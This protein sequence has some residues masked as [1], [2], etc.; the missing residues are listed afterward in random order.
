MNLLVIKEISE[1]RNIP[2]VDLANKINMSPQNLHRCIREN[3]IEASVLEK[4]SYIL[5]VPI[6]TFFNEKNN[7]AISGN[8]Q[9][10]YGIGTQTIITNEQKEI[11]Y[12]KQLLEEKER[13]I[14]H[15]LNL[16][17]IS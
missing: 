4:I 10:N 5:D 12:L 2:I 1:K 14:Q 11:E 13:L 3:K 15:L 7:Y 6:N 8:H 16:N 9:I 17:K